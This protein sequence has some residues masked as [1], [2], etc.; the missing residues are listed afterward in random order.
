MYKI[1]RENLKKPLKTLRDK[2]ILNCRKHCYYFTL[3][4]RN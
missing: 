3:E 2:K 1:H 4:L